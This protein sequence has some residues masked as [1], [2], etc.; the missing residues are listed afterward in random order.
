MQKEMLHMQQIKIKP[1]VV[2]GIG[3]LGPFTQLYGERAFA[4]SQHSFLQRVKQISSKILCLPNHHSNT[5]FDATIIIYIYYT[6]M[7][8]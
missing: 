4:A 6:Y 7:Y 5:N 3:F 1:I 2:P 8:T